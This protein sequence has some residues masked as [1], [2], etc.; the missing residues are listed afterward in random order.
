MARLL[1]E[2]ETIY[3]EEVD[4]I[5]E[6]KDVKTIMEFMNGKDAEREANPFKKMETSKPLDAVKPEENKASEE[7]KPQERVENTEPKD[8]TKND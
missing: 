5:M 8:D 4:L 7:E 6:G 2:R 1:I 3:Q